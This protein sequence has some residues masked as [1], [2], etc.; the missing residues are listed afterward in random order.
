MKRRTRYGSMIVLLT[1]FVWLWALTAGANV[2]IQCPGDTNGDGISEDPN[3][4]C[5]SIT[6]GDGYTTMADGLGLYIFSFGDAD[7]VP[8]DRVIA[9][10]TLKAQLPAPTIVPGAG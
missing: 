6:G 4:V 7:G 8:V 1:L 9:D 3:I 5:R 2:R 10:L